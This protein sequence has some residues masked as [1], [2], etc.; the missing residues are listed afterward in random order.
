MTRLSKIAIDSLKSE[1][2]GLENTLERLKKADVSNEAKHL[3]NL[4]L[5][6]RTEERLAQVNLELE[7]VADESTRE[8]LKNL[9]SEKT[10]R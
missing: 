9:D 6:Y 7:Q 2:I 10:T 5:K 1:K 3:A 8:F 4:K